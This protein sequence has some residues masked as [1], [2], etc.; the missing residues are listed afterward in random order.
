MTTLLKAHRF[1]RVDS[2]LLADGILG[3]AYPLWV[4]SVQGHCRRLALDTGSGCSSALM[5]QGWSPCPDGQS[6]IQNRSLSQ[7]AP[8]LQQPRSTELVCAWRPV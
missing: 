1:A 6:R 2:D 8:L 5:L 4:L 7:R 3:V